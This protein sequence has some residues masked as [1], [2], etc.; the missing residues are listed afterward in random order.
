V[1]PRFRQT[2][3]APSEGGDAVAYIFLQIGTDP[4][5]WVLENADPDT[6]A[7]QLSQAT[8]P[9]VL[10]IIDPLQGNLV[11]SPSAAATISVARPSPLHGY[12]PSHIALPQWPVLY[13]PSPASPTQDSPG[14]PLEPS[15]DLTALER[16]IVA[17][18]SEGTV[19]SIQ[20]AD[21]QGG[22]VLLNGATL[23]FAVLAQ[24]ND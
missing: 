19:L 20:V 17:A 10:P 2:G 21:I 5:D 16:H 11:V 1:I 9:V 22:V 13:L 14:Y 8:G 23:G 12:H 6:V 24:V 3:Q 4:T 7:A 18:M 15:T